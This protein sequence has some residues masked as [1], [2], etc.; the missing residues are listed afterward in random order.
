ME[1]ISGQPPEPDHFLRV[2]KMKKD[3]RHITENILDLTLEIIYLLTGETYT[4]VNKTSSE[5]V[6]PRGHPRV[7]DLQT[8]TQIPIPVPPSHS[9]VH[10]KYNEQ[11]ILELAN[12]IIQLLTGEVPIRC[13]DF[14]VYFSM[15]EWE[16]IEQHRGL[17]KDVM[18]ENHRPLTSLDGASNRN[19]PER[20]LRPLYSQDH[21]EESHSVP[22]EDQGE[23]RINI[24]TEAIQGEETY[25]M[26]DQQCK[27]EE[28][29]TYVR[30]NQLC[31]EEEEETYVRSNQLCKE[32]EEETYVRS[33]QLCKEEEIPTDIS[34]ADGCRGR[35]TSEGRLLLSSD[36]KIEDNI[37]QD[38][39]GE[40][41]VRQNIHPVLDREDTSSDPSNH[42]DCSADTLDDIIHRTSP[43]GAKMFPCSECGKCF[44]HRSVFVIHLRTHTGEKPFACTE[45]GKCFAQ[46]YTLVTHQRNHTGEK[47]FSCSECGKWFTRKSKLVIHQRSHTG[48]KPI[49]CSNCGKCFTDKSKLVIHQRSH[50]GEKPFS[51]SDCGKCFTEKSKLVKHQRTH[52]GAKP[53]SCATCG[54]HFTATSSLVRH[55]R[56]HTGE[57]LFP[58]SECGKCFTVKSNLA[59]HQRSHTG[60]KPFSCSECGKYFTEKSVLVRHQRTH[61]GEKPFS[62]SECGKCFTYKSD[63]VR[64]QKTHSINSARRLVSTGISKPL[65]RNKEKAELTE[66]AQFAV[67]WEVC[68]N[69]SVTLKN[70]WLCL[71]RLCKEDILGQ[72][73]ETEHF[74]R[75]VKMENDRR[76]ITQNIL[77]LTLEII[78]LLTGETYTLVSETSGESVTPKGHP[79]VSDERRRF[80]SNIPVPPPHSLVHERHNDQKILE[81]TNKIIQLLT[82]EVPIRCEDATVYFS[83]E[84]WEYIEEH[85]GLYKDVMMEN[86]RPLT[87]LDGAG[88]RNTPGRCPRPLYSQDHTEENH[89][90]LQEGQGEDRIDIKREDISGEEEMYVRVDQLCN[91]EEIPT[92]ISIADGCRSRNTSEGHLLLSSDFKIEDNIIQDSQGQNPVTLIIPPVLATGDTASDPSNHEDC[93]ADTLDVVTHRTSP[94]GAKMFP[95]SECGKCFLYNSFFIS[96]QRTHTDERPFPC[97]E[98]GKCFKVKS[99]FVI[100]QRTHTGEKPFT[101][102]DCG[103]CF[104]EKSTLVR[105]QRT[106]TGEKPFPCSQCGKCFTQKSDLVKH[107]RTHTGEKPFSCSECG[108]CFI[109]KTNL[110]MHQRIHTGEKLY[111]CS[112]CGKSFTEKSN[113]VAHQRTHTGEKPFPCSECGKCFIKKSDLVRHQKT[114]TGEKPFSCSDCGKCFTQKTNLVIHQRTHTGEKPCQ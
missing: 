113:L 24:K 62:C 94:T 43:T 86:H 85:R 91:E 11:K 82:G 9:L 44:L 46:K 93:S 48:V 104:T 32:E 38:S 110:V 77:D 64:H 98:C 75:F 106:H 99:N 16:Y 105:H 7:L 109:Q 90:V 65:V 8:R 12:K 72:P 25:V 37:V 92:G 20:C 111:L 19:T 49:S 114:H 69:V 28:E 57:R 73:P 22:Q 26:I 112:E 102:S 47:A 5:C 56:I 4:M 70:A 2:F 95:C 78:Y 67:E 31:K 18:M 45:C 51:C 29:E 30:S 58:C 103:K 54:K 10:E 39:P 34:T 61:T 17:Y 55:Q 15:E 97:S 42:K 36:Y 23:D 60:V 83:M 107:Q 52:T 71:S 59:K 41:P 33:N 53:F 87:S 74:L 63:L 21:T 27:E 40:N 1:D 68:T 96:H 100:H 50:T 3:G 81:L 88:N 76:H 14:T 108:K 79:H 80:Q 84:E 35:N 89:T 13:E 101:C 6:T 66:D